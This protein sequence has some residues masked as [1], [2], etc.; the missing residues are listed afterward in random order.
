MIGDVIQ[1]VKE[2][3]IGRIADEHDNT[4]LMAETTLCDGNHLEIGTLHGGSAIVVALVKKEYGFTGKVYCIDPL[5]GYYLKSNCPQKW[6]EKIDPV[7]KVP[8]SLDT[9]KKNMKIFDIE[10]EVIQS[11]SIPYPLN[12]EVFATAYIDG[13]HWGDAPTLDF[14]NVYPHVERFIT[15][16]NCDSKHPAVQSACNQAER[17]WMPYKRQNNV[18]IVKHPDFNS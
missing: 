12:D 10:L 9:L 17:I 14:M 4:L 15:F 8:V 2:N 5:D 1:Y 11:S 18:C 3:M 13:D 16:D 6:Q 7:S